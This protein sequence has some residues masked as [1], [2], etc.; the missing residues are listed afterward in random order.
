MQSS[1]HYPMGRGFEWRLKVAL[2]R[3][4][5]PASSPRY[6]STVMGGARAWPIMPALVAA[7]A[8]MLL[9]IT[10]SV[11]TGSANP[12]VWAERAGTTLQAVGHTPE[13]APTP[14]P[15]PANHNV[16]I[17]APAQPTH[18][19]EQEGTQAAELPEPADPKEAKERPEP[20]ESS[21]SPSSDHSVQRSAPASP[22]D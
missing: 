17:A 8:A 18:Q 21:V 12:V 1:D 13:A 7:G 22:G 10:A 3:V 2:D 9:A 15:D 6:E 4:A 19:P 16:P 5:P 20:S 11:F 14:V